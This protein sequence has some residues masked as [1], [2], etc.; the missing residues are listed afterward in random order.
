MS[1]QIHGMAH[2]ALGVVFLCAPFALRFRYGIA[3]S[4]GEIKKQLLPVRSF[5][6]FKQ[7]L[8]VTTKKGGGDQAPLPELNRRVHG[9]YSAASR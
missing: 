7:G 3:C 4:I 6:L 8:A 1:G 5:V 2:I 9:P